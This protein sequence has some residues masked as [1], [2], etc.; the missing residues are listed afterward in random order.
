MLC[1]VW[2]VCLLQSALVIREG[3]RKTIVAEEVVIGDI[4]EVKFGDKVP[5]DL[6]IL[7]S[8]SL[9]V[10]KLDMRIVVLF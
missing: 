8:Q 10:S 7:S 1:N 3:E 9:K 6:R 5:A 4:V 2:Y